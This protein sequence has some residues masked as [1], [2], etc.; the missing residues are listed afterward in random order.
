MGMQPNFCCEWNLD[1]FQNDLP[2]A[3]KVSSRFPDNHIQK[4]DKLR[5]IQYLISQGADPMQEMDLHGERATPMQRALEYG[6][7]STIKCIRDGMGRYEMAPPLVVTDDIDA[8]RSDRQQQ[9]LP[10]AILFPGQGSQY[11]TMLSEVMHL[12]PCK[13]LIDSANSVLGYNILDLCLYGPEAKLEETKFCQPAM[14]LANCCALEKLR[15]DK[16]EI[17]E[18]AM[19][20]AGLSLGEYNALWY[21]GVL[22]FEDCLRIVRV[23]ADAMQ[24]ESKKV[25]QGMLSVA[26]LDHATLDGLCQEAIRRAGQT[27]EGRDMVCQ[28]ANHLFPKGYTVSG[29]RIAVEELKMLAE[30]NGALQ[31][32]FL[33]TSGAFHTKLME[34]AGMKVL[35]SLKAKVTDMTFPN[36][37]LYM[38]VRGAPQRKGTDP[39]ELNYDLA[40]QVSQPVLWEQTIKEMIKNGITEFY[41]CGPMKQ[42]KAMMKRIDQT[43]WENTHSVSV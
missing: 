19:V 16:P 42:L 33:K 8:Y 30:Q 38:N 36:L 43:S 23:R 25:P 10:V 12:E 2:H 40:A 13:K 5:L 31:A 24:E 15:L 20:T 26:G 9:K 41:E 6:D 22:S 27:A 14:F 28:I 21:S 29:D 34:P 17:V 18:R 35:M 39:R 1:I 3:I 7:R 32:R 11:V 37:D 4:V